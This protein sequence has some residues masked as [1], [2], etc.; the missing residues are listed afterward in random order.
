MKK[1]I[2]TFIG[3]LSILLVTALLL[4][5]LQALLMPKYMSTSRE[6]ALIAELKRL[7]EACRAQAGVEVS[8]YFRP[9]EGCFDEAMLK[10][11][12][13]AGYKTVFWSFAYADWDNGR[14]P[15]PAYAKAKILD[16]LHN[17]A[18]LL[19]HPTSATN[20]AILPEILRQ[21]KTLGYRFGTLD[22]LTGGDG[23]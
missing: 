15:D 6:G 1:K 3:I 13:K 9:P 17:G 16:N 2:V 12:C 23:A 10:E 4:S 20:A 7:E 11:A 5:F 22:E 21:I 18:V 19:L 14:Q 8:K